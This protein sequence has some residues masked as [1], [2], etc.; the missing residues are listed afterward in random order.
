MRHAP[1]RTSSGIAA[2]CRH[3]WPQFPLE[4]EDCR[5]L[6]R[7]HRRYHFAAMMIFS[8]YT[9]DIASALTCN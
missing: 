2:A 4:L 9:D 8:V 5:H 6:P 3:H 7:I 1:G